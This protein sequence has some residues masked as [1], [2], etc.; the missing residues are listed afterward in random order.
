MPQQSRKLPLLNRVVVAGLGIGL[1]G[2]PALQLE[3]LLTR[4]EPAPFAEWL[5]T[6]LFIAAFVPFGVWLVV[7]SLQWGRKSQAE[8]AED[9]EMLSFLQP[10]VVSDD[11]VAHHFDN[12]GGSA[13]VF[14]DQDARQIH[15]VN[16]HTPSQWLAQASEWTVCGFDELL[17]VHRQSTEEFDLFVSR[18]RP[19]SSAEYLTLITPGGKAVIP[20][21]REDSYR[22][23]CETLLEI[24][25][26]E[27]V[28][29]VMDH[30]L[31][32]YVVIGGVLV[33]FFTAGSLAR[34]LSDD[35]FIVAGVAGAVAG[36]AGVVTGAWAF[37]R[38]R[39]R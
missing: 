30:P 28:P 6:A 21:S 24:Q 38:F 36:A 34:G 7:V 13:A 10:F 25:P 3:N 14:V 32:M 2:S 15:F 1:I 23:L 33:G 37:D 18:E 39:S 31:M 8:L 17:A 26:A 11:A 29:R 16:C 12:A 4:Q 35:Q 19:T 27:Q 22:E 20:G 5:L 9:V